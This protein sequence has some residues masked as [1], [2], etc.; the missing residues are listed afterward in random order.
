MQINNKTIQYIKNAFL[1]AWFDTLIRYKKSFIGPF[2]YTITNFCGIVVFSV[3]WAGLVNEELDV[4]VPKLTVGL[5]L[6]QM[7]SGVLTEAPRMLTEN[8]SMLRNVKIPLWFLT[9]RLMGRQLINF[10][11]NILLIVAVFIYY[12]IN[13]GMNIIY[14]II[15]VMILIFELSLVAH[16]LAGVG[17]RFRDVRFAME[18]FV[19]FLFFV[20]PIFFKSESVAN[21]LMWYNPISYMIEVVREPLLGQV[22]TAM[23]YQRF[24][25][26]VVA[27]LLLTVVFNKIAKGK[28]I[29]WIN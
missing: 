7:I 24:G 27:T 23:L 3:V 11:H 22:P 29:Y 25:L 6:W 12:G 21:N 18:T 15:G 16:I 17:A 1:L 19:P 8:V 2:W 10:S 5:I 13:P 14:S 4:F 28:Q 9:V 20:S 26:I